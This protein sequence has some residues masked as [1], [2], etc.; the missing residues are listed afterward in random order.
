MILLRS[1]KRTASPGKGSRRIPLAILLPLA[2][3]LVIASFFRFA[4][5]GYSEFQGDE[6]DAMMPAARCPAGD[7][8]ARRGSRR[9]PVEIL[10]P[11]LPWRLAQTTDEA[12]ACLPFALAGLGTL[13]TVFLLGRKL[14]G[15][16]AGFAAVGVAVL[17]GLLIAFSRI[18]Q[19]LGHRAGPAPGGVGAWEWYVCGQTRGCPDGTFHRDRPARTLRCPRS[20]A[21]FGLHCAARLRTDAPERRVLRWWGDVCRSGDWGMP[22]VIVPFYGPYLLTPQVGATGSY[23]GRR[24][25]EGLLKNRIDHFLTYSIFY[26]S[27]LYLALTGGWSWPSW[28]GASITPRPSA[29]SPEPGSGRPPGRAGRR[30]P[31]GWPAG[32]TIGALIWR[33]SPGG[34]F[35]RR[36]LLPHRPPPWSRAP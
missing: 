34:H 1:A 24:I 6:I 14:G 5:L 33:R 12:S 15:N 25:G 16:P 19:Y 18:V 10:L 21:S 13:A 9:G 36:V 8:D 23:L 11:M 22:L 30:G 7:P 3:I 28:L 26:N 17:N 32:L 35:P 31:A 4:S 29:G 2:L 20:R 27:F